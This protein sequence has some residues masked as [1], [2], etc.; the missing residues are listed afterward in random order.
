MNIKLPRTRRRISFGSAAMLLVASALLAQLLGFL[1][2]KLVNSNFNTPFTPPDQNAGVYFAA[3]N[4]PDFFFFTIAAGALGVAFMPYLSD[5]LNKGDRKGMWELS[6]SLLN[7]LGIIMLVVGVFILIFAKPLIQYIVAPGL[8]PDQLENAA[9]LMRFLALNP[10]L[11]TI[12]GILTS[13]QQTMGR[14]FFYAIAPLFYNLAIIAS[15]YIFKDSMGIVG[16]G[17][18][19]LAGGILQLVVVAI[20]TVGLGFHWRPYIIWKSQDFREML[21]QLPPRSLDQGIDQVQSIV[22]TNFASNKLLGGANAISNYNNAYILQTAPVLLIGTA[23]S[24]AIFP[25]LNN[26]LSQG[27]PDLFRADFLRTLRLILWI[28]MPVVVIC[29][30]ARGYL[31]RL[32]FSNNAPDI[33]VIFGFLCVAILFRTIYTL[34]SRWFYAQKDSKTPLLVS[35]FTISLNL[36]LA[37]VLSRP[38]NYG[39]A[40]LAI[41]QSIVAAVEVVILGVIMLVRD[42]KLFDAE[43]WSGVFRII[44]VTGFSLVAGY[45][46]VSLIPLGLED[47]GFVTL[48]AKLFAIAG[49]TL[50]THVAISGLFGLDEIRPFWGWIKRVML[51]RV[52]VDY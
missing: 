22:E 39:L 40:G 41:A 18:G 52:K 33:A 20:G 4:I 29:F 47:R 14:F 45:M 43:F 32:I 12:S 1:R 9:T 26:R 16:M 19:A 49:V 11:F 27:R 15:I 42:P 24:T 17:V 30:F 35:V 7:L 3:F 38:D 13:T 25:R 10:F 34:I 31:A 23:I 6:M 2:T 50:A 36:I 44:S 28:T 51:R 5:R 46:M 37:Y 21:R 8:T 48:G